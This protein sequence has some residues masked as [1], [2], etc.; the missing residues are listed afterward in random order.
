M[1]LTVPGSQP[2]GSLEVLL[3]SASGS[4]AL[5]QGFGFPVKSR[6]FGK[7]QIPRLLM[8][9]PGEL[10]MALRHPWIQSSWEACRRQLPTVPS[11][12]RVQGQGLE[13]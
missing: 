10:T 11:A 6:V 12:R 2:G 8:V 13:F 9:L 3:M 7:P 1:I 5:H 4:G